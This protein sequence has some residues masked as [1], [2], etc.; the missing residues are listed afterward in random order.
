MLPTTAELAV[1]RSRH[2]VIALLRAMRPVQ[3]LKNGVLFAGLVFGHKLLDGDAV[4]RASLAA[5]LFCLLSSGFYL[6][7]DVQDRDSD[8][9]HPLKRR[10][11]VAA[12]EISPRLALSMGI[13]MVLLALVC[14]IALG[15]SFML[16]LLT[17]ALLM[18]TYNLG[19]KHLVILD[20]FAIATG[21]VI[22]AAAG[23]IAVS[24][25]ISP[26]LLICTMLLALLI[27]FGKRRHELLTLDDAPLHRQNLES[28]S[29]ALLEQCVA[30]SAAGTLIAYALYTFDADAAPDD[31]RMMLTIPVV[32]FGVFR[33]LFLLYRR[34][35]GGAPETM[36]LGDRALLAAIALWGVMAA[37]LFYTGP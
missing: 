6:V 13:G 17:Y 18:T 32:A 21:F 16:A 35:D 11:P 4:L 15:V 10:R 25:A 9:V 24:V 1:L 19:L 2:G 28:Y 5:I 36:L 37:F 34:Q 20:V 23:A 8:L 7:N 12:G 30:V 22:R 26:W 31:R 27:G 3:W 14:S 29:R 33:Y